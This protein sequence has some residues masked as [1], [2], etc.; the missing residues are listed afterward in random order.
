[1][2]EMSQEAKSY[3]AVDLGASSGRVIVGRLAHG[4]VTLEEAHRFPTPFIESDGHFRWDLK[5]LSNHIEVGIAKGL[6]LAP[7]VRSLSVDS[8]AVDFVSVDDDG[9]P[10]RLP[11]CYRD[12]RNDGMMA[13]AFETISRERL[14]EITGIQYLPFNTLFQ[15]VADQQFEP[16]AMNAAKQLLLIADYFNFVLGGRPVA[17][18]SMASTTHMVDAKSQ[19]WSD[20][21][22]GAFSINR[23]TLPEIV[24]PGTVIGS[25][26]IAPSVKVV[27][28]CSHDTGAAVAAVPAN[29]GENWAYI[30][31]GTW[32]LIG[33]ELPDPILSPEALEAGFT[34]EIG[35]AGSIRFLKNISGLWILQECMKEWQA[36]DPDLSWAVLGSEATAAVSTG[37]RVDVDDPRFMAPGS[38]LARL[39]AY[40]VESGIQFPTDR[41]DVARLILESLAEAYSRALGLLEN[42]S[43]RRITNIHVVGGGSQN[44]LLCQLAANETGCSVVAGPVEATALG[45]VLVQAAALGDLSDGV[46]IREVVR[47]SF[48]LR[49]YNPQ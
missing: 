31:S 14:Y 4:V 10:T 24:Q 25:A 22:L 47:R 5:A 18:L 29:E 44:E 30:S 49:T 11:Y 16:Q 3:L 36:D 48:D 23:S 26:A 9:L 12:P 34:N 6:Q 21:I 40:C 38:M 2:Q 42:V 27:A 35:L 19:D 46:S 17:E 45:N 39:E 15:L 13:K 33:L 37:A 20:E 1:M 43:G 41:G 7:E 32:S 8:W 28:S